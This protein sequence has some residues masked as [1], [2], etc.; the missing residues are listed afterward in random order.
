MPTLC[1]KIQCLTNLHAGSGDSGIG[2]IDK[3]V[4]RDAITNMPVI[5]SSSL[6]GAFREYFEEGPEQDNIAKYAKAIFG[7]KV[8]DG[9][10]DAGGGKGD[11]VFHEA[12]LLALPVGS[13][14]QPYFM[15]TSKLTL[16][17]WIEKAKLLLADIDKNLIAEVD[18]LPDLK[19]DSPVILG[20]AIPGLFVGEYEDVGNHTGNFPLLKKMLGVNILLLH[21]DA[22]KE[23]CSDYNLPV[24]A[25]NNLENGESQNLWY[26]QIVPQQSVFAFYT[27]T[28]KSTDD[29][30]N[31]INGK[32]VQLGANS[33]IGYGY[34][35][36]TKL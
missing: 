11:V 18:S 12:Q 16:Q 23:Q 28:N 35:Q 24:I 1:Y 8:K 22:F 13:N 14:K 21:H 17:N 36:I 20:S 5:Y 29:F 10:G 15:A 7:K 31:N 25:R 27:Y 4:Q 19:D 26:E 34:C 30:Y 3:M 33:S 32:V 2:I 6:K 9:E